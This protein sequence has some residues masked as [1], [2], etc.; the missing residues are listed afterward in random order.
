[1]TA[2]RPFA[3]QTAPFFLAV[4]V[5]IAAFFL[6]GAGK[7]YVRGNLLR[8]ECGDQ[9]FDQL[10]IGVVDHLRIRMTVHRRQMYDCITLPHKGAELGFIL[11]EAVLERDPFELF[12]QCAEI[13]VKMG[14][15]KAGLSGNSDSNHFIS[16][17]LNQ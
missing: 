13:V 14:T 9:L 10:N 17:Q 2:F 12:I 11:K 1:M 6:R 15:D 5:G 4:T 3:Q 8:F 7:E 16:S